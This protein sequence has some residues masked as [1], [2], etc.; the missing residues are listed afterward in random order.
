MVLVLM[1]L[2]LR[3]RE[4]KGSENLHFVL[5]TMGI[6]LSLCYGFMMFLMMEVRAGCDTHSIFL[7]RIGW[8]MGLLHYLGLNNIESSI[9]L[10]SPYG[11]L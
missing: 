7:L 3:E 6:S 5:C 10:F 2:V 8:R 4:S 11:T 1:M 9:V